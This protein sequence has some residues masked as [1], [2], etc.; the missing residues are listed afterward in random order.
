[1]TLGEFMALEGAPS[2]KAL[3]ERTGISEAS[4]SRLRK[5][6]QV[7]SASAMEAIYKATGGRVTPNDFLGI[8]A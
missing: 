1:M 4:I 2:A 5:G 8:A 7:P 3:A 6:L